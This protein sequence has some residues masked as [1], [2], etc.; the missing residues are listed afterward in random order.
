MEDQLRITGL[1]SVYSGT[2]AGHLNTCLASISKQTRPLEQLVVVFDGPVDGAVEEAIATLGKKVTIVRLPANKGLGISLGIGLEQCKHQ[3]TARFDSD[4]V[5]PPDRL[6]LQADYFEAHKDIHLLGGQIE[7]FENSPGDID[8][9]R[10]VPERVWPDFF[11][12]RR[13]PLNHMTAMFRTDD[14]R[15]IGGYSGMRLMQDY[16]LWLRA[17]SCGLIAANLP[18]TLAYARI[19]GDAGLYRRRRGIDNIMSELVVFQAKVKAFKFYWLPLVVLSLAAR[20]ATRLL[21]AK[22][23]KMIYRSMLR[24]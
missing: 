23:L 13:N 10:L 8:Q 7:E 15:R 18:D 24:K 11:T 17:M 3:L 4:D 12:L 21:P 9:A 16:E 5:Y 20:M 22:A 2:D 6:K 19:G 1:M 14:V